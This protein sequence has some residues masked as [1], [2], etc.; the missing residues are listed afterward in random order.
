M[1]PDILTC[2][3]NSGGSNT[4]HIHSNVI[5][6]V[7]S[8]FPV[9]QKVYLHEVT[10]SL[11]QRE[12]QGTKYFKHEPCFISAIGIYNCTLEFNKKK[13]SKCLALSPS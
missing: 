3:Q 9:F 4:T 12:L 10:N 8:L 1:F 5:Q 7:V 13:Q 6:N 11:P 2:E